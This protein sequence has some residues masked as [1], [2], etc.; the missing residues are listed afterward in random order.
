MDEQ[1]AQETPKLGFGLMRLPRRGLGIDVAQVSRM[2]D[3]FLEAGFTY[4][5]TAHVY[6]GSEDA[7]RKAL[8]ERRPR[9][10]YTLATKLYAAMSPSAKSAKR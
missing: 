6:A 4:F 3:L 7:I 2:V 8:V 10:S 9:E 1:V 5:D